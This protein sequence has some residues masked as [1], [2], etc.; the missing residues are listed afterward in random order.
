MTNIFMGTFAPCLA[1]VAERYGVGYVLAEDKPASEKV[2]GLAVELGIEARKFRTYDELMGHVSK[3]GAIE[4][5][6]IAGFGTILKNDFISKCKT[7][8]NVHL[9]DVLTCRGR[10]PLPTAILQKEVFMTATIH[11]I[12]SEK[13]DAGPVLGKI[14]LPIDY[15]KNYAYNEAMLVDAAAELLRSVLDRRD[16]TGISWD[17]ARSSYCP[18]LSSDIL[19]RIFKISALKD[20]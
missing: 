18:R 15:E 3:L 16:F 2:C 10:H 4:T 5:C 7:I 20:L 1:V 11:R 14:K 12:D 19:S 13:I 8:V 6:F 9:G 17:A